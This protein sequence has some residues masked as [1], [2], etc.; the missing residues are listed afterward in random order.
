M[1]SKEAEIIL[2]LLSINGIG[3][4]LV[5]R[6]IHEL[7]RTNKKIN[8]L[9]D[10][11]N[12]VFL[13]QYLSNFDFK[14]INLIESNIR[15]YIKN[16]EDINA[17]SLTLFDDNY[18]QLLLNA[19][20]KSAPPLLTYLGNIEILKQKSIGFCGSRNASDKGLEVAKDCASQLAKNNI[21]IVS[22]HAA[23]VDQTTHF[24]A[25]E[26]G[27]AT[28]I[29]LPEGLLNF[30]IRESLKNVWD[31]NR[32]LVI[33]EFSP[34]AIWTA[35]RAMQ[36]NSTIIGLSIAMILIE[37]GRTGGSIDA[38]K[39]TLAMKR[40]L[41]IPVY[42]GM[43]ESAVGNRILLKNGAIELK[44]SRST[45]KANLADIFKNLKDD[46]ILYSLQNV[47]SFY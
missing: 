46:S 11:N 29:V 9:F 1:I 44:K 3:P 2:K 12:L 37:A 26:S 14:Q 22:G 7:I 31:W 34:K 24:A 23:G 18:P 13:K 45:G 33:S 47:F 10:N 19:L 32:V 20:G 28:I 21:V 6:I 30:K 27:G 4:S 16:L 8:Q 39:K 17:C 25:L 38:G 43:P 42:E 36:R 15:N 5:N 35:S 40:R 41:Y